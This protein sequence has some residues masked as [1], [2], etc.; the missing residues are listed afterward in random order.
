MAADPSPPGLVSNL[1]IRSLQVLCAD[2]EP[3]V[4][5]IL[6]L[7][8]EHEGHHVTCV[9]DGQAAFHRIALDLGF[10]DLLIVDHHMP[11]LTGLE[12]VKLL[13]AVKFPGSI[14]VY[15]S[16]LHEDHH[17]AY[18]TFEVEHILMKP[19][20]LGKLLEIIRAIAAPESNPGS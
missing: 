2:D 13:R 8:L 7:A 1:P 14:I 20:Q 17:R 6:R 15:S 18:R 19:A 10:F 9:G 16:D 3:E 5:M 12:L 4:A 11:G